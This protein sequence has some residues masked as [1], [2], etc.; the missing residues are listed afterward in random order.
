MREGNNFLAT[1]VFFFMRH[2]PM[3]HQTCQNLNA[4]KN[5]LETISPAAKSRRKFFTFLGGS[6]AA[7]ALQGCGAGG[8]LTLTYTPNSATT[9][10]TSPPTAPT[11]PVTTAPTTPPPAGT[12]ATIVWQSIPAVAF[13]QGVPSSFSVAD[14][15]SVA[16]ASSFSLNVSS[17]LPAGVTFDASH[18]TFVY[19]GVGAI[20]ALDGVVLTA[21]VA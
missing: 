16:N 15:V 1:A 2:L 12:T 3:N 20:G 17:S 14:Y 4:Q 6:A 18:R 13:V 5:E 9:T 21:T 7:L 11:P 8:G 19:D 10:P